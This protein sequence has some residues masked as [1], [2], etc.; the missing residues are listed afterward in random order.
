MDF[1][2]DLKM[3]FDILYFKDRTF[4]LG[5]RIPGVKR[6]IKGRQSGVGRGIGC[7]PRGVEE[8]MLFHGSPEEFR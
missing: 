8:G 6:N 2:L 3:I 5:V 7:L 4:S 1:Y